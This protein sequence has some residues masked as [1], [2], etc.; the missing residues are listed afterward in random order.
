VSN[1]NP[2]IYVEYRGYIWDYRG[3]IWDNPLSD[4]CG[5]S[6]LRLIYGII[7]VIC[8]DWKALPEVGCTGKKVFGSL[9][10]LI[11]G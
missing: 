8:S 10:Q 2:M 11:R 9:I 5:I 1:K 3:Y 4:I 6:P 7:G